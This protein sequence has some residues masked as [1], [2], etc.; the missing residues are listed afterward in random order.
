MG[1]LKALY[2]AQRLKLV[3]PRRNCVAAVVL[4]SPLTA[5][6]YPEYLTK[7]PFVLIPVRRND[8]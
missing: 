1:F 7:D 2:E 8:R 4:V 3:L 6:H 5:L